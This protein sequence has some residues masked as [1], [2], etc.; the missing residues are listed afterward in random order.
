MNA[1]GPNSQLHHNSW[2][3]GEKKRLARYK[4]K[5]RNKK[6]SNILLAREWTPGLFCVIGL[7]FASLF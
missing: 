5:Q 3:S 2:I 4:S 1:P 7:V 6:V